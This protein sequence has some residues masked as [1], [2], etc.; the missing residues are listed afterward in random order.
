MMEKYECLGYIISNRSF[1]LQIHNSYLLSADSNP[2][3][4]PHS[5][6]AGIATT[7]A[8]TLHVTKGVF[9]CIG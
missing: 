3:T 5:G 1:R 4:A 9:E 7:K 6:V 8:K 2:Q